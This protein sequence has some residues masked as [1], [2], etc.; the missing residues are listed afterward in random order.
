MKTL[1]KIAAL[2]LIYFTSTQVNSQTISIKENYMEFEIHALLNG[3]N[4]KNYS[5]SIYTDGIKIDSFYCSSK[6]PVQ[7]TFDF[8]KIYSL[9]F[10]KQNCDDKIIIV[11]TKV[12]KGIERLKDEIRDFELEMSNNLLQKSSDTADF[13]VA[14]LVIDKIEKILV[15]CES[16][17]TLMHH[18]NR[19]YNPSNS[20]ASL[21][22]NAN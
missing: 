7:F 14:I 4:T 1:K 21:T 13:P 17:H 2:V 11:N 9:R 15:V 3:F 22:A 5:V 10:Q 12:P 6:R 19:L 20:N 8:N 18:K 16:Y